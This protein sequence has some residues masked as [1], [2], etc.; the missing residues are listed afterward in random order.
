M[1]NLNNILFAC[2]QSYSNCTL[3]HINNILFACG[4]SY[5][6]CPLPHINNIYIFMWTML[7]QLHCMP[8]LNNIYIFMWTMLLQ[9]H[10]MPH[11]N[12]IIFAC[13]QSYSNCTVCHISITLYL[14]VDNLTP[15]ALYA[16]SQK[17]SLC[18][19]AILLQLHSMPHLN[20][21]LFACGQS[22]SNCTLPHINNILFACGQSYS[23]CPLPHLNNIIF[24]CGQSY[25]NCTVCHISITF[26]F[27][28][29]QC[30]SNCTVSHI[31]ITLSLHV[32]NLTPI[33]LYATSQ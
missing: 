31:S 15:I 23:N 13:G 2:G 7:L 18:M 25:S 33:A 24:A 12:N 9:L 32:D 17:H 16:K 6:N 10:C 26:I 21:I 4:Q 28:R 30:Y 11:L 14:H 20:N 8:H 19:W 3:P 1:Q 5:S 22:Y 27:S 29:G